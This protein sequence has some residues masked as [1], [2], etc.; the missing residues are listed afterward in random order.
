MKLQILAFSYYRDSKP[1]LASTE[2]LYW[3]T[4]VKP[5]GSADSRQGHMTR[6]MSSPEQFPFIYGPSFLYADWSLGFSSRRQVAPVLQPYTCLALLLQEKRLLTL[7]TGCNSHRC[8]AD[9]D[10]FSSDCPELALGPIV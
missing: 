5:T 8:L 9:M 10:F 1:K 2:E 7:F 6:M 4:S 3:L